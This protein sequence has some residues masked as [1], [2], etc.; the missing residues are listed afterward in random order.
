M[1]VNARP[2]NVATV[3]SILSQT[4]SAW[5]LQ[6]AVYAHL[7]HDTPHSGILLS[8][9][10]VETMAHFLISHRLVLHILRWMLQD[11]TYPECFYKMLGPTYAKE[12]PILF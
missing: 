5:G 3:W 1:S 6:E 8:K 7:F 10:L 9:A 11:E 2:D 12:Y 4:L